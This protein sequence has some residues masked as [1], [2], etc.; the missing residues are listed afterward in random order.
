MEV[1]SNQ[2]AEMDMEMDQVETVYDE[3]AAAD[4]GSEVPGTM[5]STGN[6]GTVPKKAKTGALSWRAKE[7]DKLH[8]ARIDYETVLKTLKTGK[9]RGAG[10]LWW[11]RPRL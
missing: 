5:A 2:S 11:G 6:V 10:P 7:M 1:D 8:K 3:P 4:E 9:R